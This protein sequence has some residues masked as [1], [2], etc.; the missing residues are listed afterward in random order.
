[1]VAESLHTSCYNP[2]KDALPR[3]AAA[4]GNHVVSIVVPHDGYNA[5]REGLKIDRRIR[6][7]VVMRTA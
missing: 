2:H 3:G 4:Q 5:L 1:L 6:P 7:I